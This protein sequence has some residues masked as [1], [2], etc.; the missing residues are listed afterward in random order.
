MRRP[1][2]AEKAAGRRSAPPIPADYAGLVL[3]TGL[4]AR[5]AGVD[6]RDRR[7]LARHARDAALRDQTHAV[8]GTELL[9]VRFLHD[10][11]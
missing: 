10:R 6:R 8:A 9:A 3:P 2:E 5:R 7:S 11:A 4:R 1:R